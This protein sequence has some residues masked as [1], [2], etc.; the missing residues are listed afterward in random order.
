MATS[1]ADSSQADAFGLSF[2]FTIE[3]PNQKRAVSYANTIAR[4]FNQVMETKQPADRVI[5]NYFREH[6]KHG[7]KDRRVIRETFFGLF[8]WWGWLKQLPSNQDGLIDFNQLYLCAQ[9]EKHPWANIHHV[10]A[11]VSAIRPEDNQGLVSLEDRL[12]YLANCYSNIQFD[13]KQ[14]LPDWFWQQISLPENK[15]NEFIRIMM[16]RPPIWCRTQGLKVSDAIKQL[17]KQDVPAQASTHF[18]D[19]LSLGSKSLNLDG[20]TLYKEG[21]LEIQDLA[22]QVIGHVCAPKPEEHWWDTCAG[23]GGKSLQLKTHMLAQDS[24]A[25]GSITASDIRQGPLKELLKRAK[26]AGYKH[27]DIAPWQS[28]SLPVTK[29]FDGVLVDAPCSCLGTWRRNP[30]MRWTDDETAVLSKPELQLD[31]L[32]RSSRAVKPGG[33]LVYATCSL[34]TKENESVV[35]E[36]LALH[37]E[38]SLEMLTHPFTQE[39]SKML[40][41]WPHEADCD[42][43]FV[44]RMI[45]QR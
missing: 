1:Q 35:T 43:M 22:S 7:S 2:Q 14:L 25:K 26:R 17:L 4:L 36:F 27:I 37:P 8:R 21:K 44:V 40:T 38:F 23:A 41:I 5:A 30:D 39:Q 9:L 6:K 18:D 32:S 11:Q 12:N 10:W 42:G 16:T 13:T 20:V 33:K 28:D 24:Q 31:I 29:L 3:T 34:A 45:R 19:A 15:H